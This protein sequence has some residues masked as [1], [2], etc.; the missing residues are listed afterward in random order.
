LALAGGSSSLGRPILHHIVPVH[1]WKG[2]LLVIQSW[3]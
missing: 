2:A 1:R 3:Y